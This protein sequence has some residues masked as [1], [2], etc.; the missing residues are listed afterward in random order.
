MNYSVE[1]VNTQF[2]N[3]TFVD[4][5]YSGHV[6][7]A[8]DAA[9]TFVRL[10]L[11]EEGFTRKI[12]T[13]QM[14]T[15]ADLDRDLTDQPRIIVEKEPDSIAAS[16]SLSAQPELRYFKAERYEVVMYK[17]ASND[18]RKSKYELATYKSNIQQILQENSVKD[19]QKQEDPKGDR[20]VVTLNGKFLPYKA[21]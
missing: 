4:K 16:F 20:V 2:I 14:V 13:P 21:W 15:S 17:V 5:V 3:Q 6:K 10:K 11:R 19:I 8:M 12:L 9:S 18:F 1:T 7:E